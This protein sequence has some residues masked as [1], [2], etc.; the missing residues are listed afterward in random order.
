VTGRRRSARSTDVAQAA[1]VSQKTVSR[2]LNDEP[3]VKDEVRE[4]VL[5]AARELGYRPNGAARALLSGRTRRIGVVALGSSL[6]GPAS[7]LLGL[8]REA[9]ARGY[10]LSIANTDEDDADGVT[11]AVDSLLR[12]GVDAIVLS[13]PVDLG[14]VD[15]VVDVP[16]LTLGPLPGLKAPTVIEPLGSSEQAAHDATRHL[17]DLGHTTVHHVAGPQRWLDAQARLAGWRRALTEA[18]ARVPDV[19]FGDWSAAGGFAAGVRLAARPE[20]T[21]VFAAND[22]MAIGLMRALTAAGRRVPEDVSVVG[23]DD[24]PLAAYVNP[25]LTTMAQPFEAIASAGLASL[26][27]AVEDPASAGDTQVLVPTRLVLRESTAP[28]PIPHRPEAHH[29]QHH[30]PQ[31]RQQD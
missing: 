8:E 10:A 22:D 17:L 27:A 14:Q 16:V 19:Q 4:R 30:R 24:V 2:V 12:Q 7:L 11:L 18:A 29:Q 23:V 31:C 20:V 6:Y 15:L 5:A 26:I 13:E 28:P 25:P 3:Y 9:R 1:G 21:A